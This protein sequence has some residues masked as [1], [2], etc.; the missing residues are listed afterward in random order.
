[1]ARPA[2]PALERNIV[3]Y[4]SMEMVI[5]IFEAEQLRKF[6]LSCIANSHM[7]AETENP[8]NKPGK[9]F[10][11]IFWGI[12]EDNDILP[13]YEIEKLASLLQYRNDIA[14]RVDEL[15]I[16]LNTDSF[17]LHKIKYDYTALSEIYKLKDKVQT[18][19]AKKFPMTANLN[20]HFLTPII[21]TL[22]QEVSKLSNRINRQLAKRIAQ[23]YERKI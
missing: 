19:M 5:F 7:F 20:A 10:Y 21:D 12:I 15:L 23:I 9:R 11:E 18:N 4:R 1:M 8:L 6:M 2:L 17:H 3:K 14:H 13:S 16:D 22:K